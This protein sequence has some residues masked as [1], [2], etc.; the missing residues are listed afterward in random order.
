MFRR[1]FNRLRNRAADAGIAA[2][3]F[4]LVSELVG[5]D[6][7]PGEVDAVA[8]GVAAALAIIGR[9]REQRGT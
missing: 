5:V 8:T 1:L 6:I 2:L 3:I 9:W 4:G 7:A